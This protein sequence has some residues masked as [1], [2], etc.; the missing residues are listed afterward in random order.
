M[1]LDINN[2]YPL[3]R[4]CLIQKVLDCYTWKLPA[5][6]RKQIRECME[7]VRFGMRSTLIYFQNKYY[8][9]NRVAGNTTSDKDIGLAIGG[10]ESAFLANL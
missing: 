10:Y 5:I 7:I 6:A 4:V 1:S 9:Y 3:I 2:T 8:K